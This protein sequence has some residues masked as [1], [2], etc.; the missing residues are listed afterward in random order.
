MEK[1]TRDSDSGN[2]RRE[3]DETLGDQS[4]EVEI[5]ITVDND[6]YSG[7]YTRSGMALSVHS[8]V[9]GDTIQLWSD[10]PKNEDASFQAF[11]A[12]DVINIELCEPTSK[13]TLFASSA[14]PAVI[15][16]KAPQ[17]NGEVFWIYEISNPNELFSDCR[18]EEDVLERL[19][20]SERSPDEIVETCGYTLVLDRPEDPSG[21]AGNPPEH[22]IVIEVIRDSGREP[23]YEFY[24]IDNPVE[25]FGD[26]WGDT[27]EM[28]E[29]IVQHEIDPR[30]SYETVSMKFERPYG[31][32]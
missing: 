28:F 30:L 21:N 11:R 8:G 2:E 32:L 22:S 25:I 18:T 4:P 6:R 27:P 14:D 24:D 17:K 19:I 3:L 7:T 16:E 9:S 1:P 15:F 13:P 31:A 20:D 29:S 26:S 5:T 23:T 10:N 12:Q